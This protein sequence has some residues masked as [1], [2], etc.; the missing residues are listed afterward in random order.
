[1]EETAKRL[2]Q[3]VESG[4]RYGR[5]GL[6][7]EASYRYGQAAAVIQTLYE[8]HA[9][10]VFELPEQ[11]QSYLA[12]MHQK[13]AALSDSLSASAGNGRYKMSGKREDARAREGLMNV[14]EMLRE[15]LAF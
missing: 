2:Q 11:Y 9:S 13:L 7:Y 15:D 1:M 8:L 6:L 12:R 4:R 3:L 5:A 14:L 10:G